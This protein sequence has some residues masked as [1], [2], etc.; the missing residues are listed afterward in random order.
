LFGITQLIK[1]L[2]LKRYKMTTKK[3]L[4]KYARFG[5]LIA[6]FELILL[7]IFVDFFKIFYLIAVTMAFIISSATGFFLQKRYTF[8]NKKKCVF[9]QY[10]KYLT[11]YFIGLIINLFLVA[12]IVSLLNV[13]YIFAQLIANFILFYWYFYANKHF[14]FK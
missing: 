5:I 13:W 1:I 6:I 4:K 12:I 7:F 11:I 10:T 14:T 2:L 9:R 3:Q 8:C